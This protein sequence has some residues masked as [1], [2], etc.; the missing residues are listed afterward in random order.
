MAHL[1]SQLI[2]ASSSP[3]RPTPGESY[4]MIPELDH[5]AAIQAQATPST[6]G[7]GPQEEDSST[8]EHNKPSKMRKM[9]ESKKK[10]A[11]SKS[12]PDLKRVLN[13]PTTGGQAGR[14]EAKDTIAS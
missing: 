3:E 2:G 1:R 7:I 14:P 4:Q 8:M 6:S 10:V 11:P 5:S 13:P 12:M 9:K